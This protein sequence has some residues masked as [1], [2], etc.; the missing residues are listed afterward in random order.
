ME[1]IEPAT[2]Y[3]VVSNHQSIT[4]IPLISRLPLTLKWVAKKSLFDVPVTGW[5]MRMAGDIPVD[6]R[7]P[8][9]KQEVL[10]TANKCLQQNCS[11]LFFPEGRRTSD[12]RLNR[13]GRG[14]FELAVSTKTPVLPIVIDGLYQVLPSAQWKFRTTER[15]RLRVLPPVETNGMAIKDAEYLRERIR[16]KMLQQLSAWRNQPEEQIDGVLLEA[17]E[18]K[19][20]EKVDCPLFY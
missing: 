17:R 10:N 6:L 13:F 19:T 20:D 3:L 11:V 15:I 5:M 1:N 4:D 8:K 18:N 12:G 2:T 14:A 9:N 7:N 16:F